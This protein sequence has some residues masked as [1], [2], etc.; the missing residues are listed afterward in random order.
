MSDVRWVGVIVGAAFL[1]SSVASS[2]TPAST[3]TPTATNAAD[4]LVGLWKAKR[5]FG[6]F[7]RGA[8]VITE[9]GGSYAADM[10]GQRVPV[11]KDGGELMFDLPNGQPGPMTGSD[12][13]ISV[14]E[15]R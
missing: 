4:E 10:V 7:A 6:P 13:S 8:L 2:Q 5:W 1:L 14:R 11:R 15:G 12:A 3:G 9:S